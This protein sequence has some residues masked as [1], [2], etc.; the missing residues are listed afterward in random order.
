MTEFPETRSSLLAQLGSPDQALAWE[1][2][3]ECYQPVIYRMARRHGMQDADAQD[4]SQTVL[5]R[6]ANSV[7]RGEPKDFN[8]RF[9]HWLRKV[10]KNTIC[11]MLSRSP[12]DN[13]VGGSDFQERLLDQ[14]S[15]EWD[16]QESFEFEA[17]REA[18]ARAAAIVRTEVAGETWQAFHLTVV[19]GHSCSSVAD[20]TGQSIGSV[21]AARS[22]IMKRLR[23][24]VQRMEAYEC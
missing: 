4:L 15:P 17:K 21:Y 5:V 13:A 10:A 1:E 19:E 3:V 11:S 12:R 14:P 7:G 23:Q 16:L 8:I 22:R 24:H 9:R 6:V 20:T 18:Y 2:F